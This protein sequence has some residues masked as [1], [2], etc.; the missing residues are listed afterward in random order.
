MQEMLVWSEHNS[1]PALLFTIFHYKLFQ[2]KPKN[3]AL[4]LNLCK[5][6]TAYGSFEMLSRKNNIENFL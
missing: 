1:T 2:Q 4:G 6:W 3:L 5:V